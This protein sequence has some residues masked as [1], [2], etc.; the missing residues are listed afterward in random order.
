[1][2]QS[3]LY[4]NEVRVE[5]AFSQLWFKPYMSLF[6]EMFKPETATYAFDSVDA[7]EDSN[8]MLMIP[9]AEYVWNMD[10]IDYAYKVTDVKKFK[11]KST[12]E[13]HP[14]NGL[15]WYR[16]NHWINANEDLCNSEQWN[17]TKSELKSCITTVIHGLIE[18]QKARDYMA[19]RGIRLTYAES[20]KLGIPYEY[21]CE[22]EGD[23]FYD[24][25]CDEK[26]V[27][28]QQLLVNDINAG[29]NIYPKLFVPRND[30]SVF[31]SGF[32]RCPERVIK[33]R[34]TIKLANLLFYLH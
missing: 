7:C 16:P 29:T 10:G 26:N 28:T 4:P 22:P 5:K 32:V 21:D 1:M 2:M 31:N 6:G 3:L 13:L 30:R 11:I 9:S 8:S 24:E 19:S 15:E 25:H 23:P 14:L 34:S 17:A 18:I 20:H 33:N 27:I 12:D